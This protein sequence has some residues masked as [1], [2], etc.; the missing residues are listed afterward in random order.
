MHRAALALFVVLALA[1]CAQPTPYQ[2]ARDGY[3]FSQQRLEDNRYRIVFSG[4]SLTPLPVVEDYMLYRSAEITLE[5]GYDYFIV[6][7]KQTDKSTRYLATF[8]DPFPY[9]G[10]YWRPDRRV[11][12]GPQFQTGDY[13]PIQSFATSANITLHR[14]KKPADNPEAHDARD[15]VARLG[16]TIRYPAPESR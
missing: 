4:N 16:P 11:W 13:R 3:G 14:G 15:V 9:Y 1:A 2:P 8:T 7:D 6:A 5:A 12:Y 10:P